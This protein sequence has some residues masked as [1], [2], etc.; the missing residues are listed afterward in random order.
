MIS[1]I[2]TV[3]NCSALSYR[4]QWKG[5]TMAKGK[6]GLFSGMIPVFAV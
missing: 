1:S 2:A 6:H 3:Y 5:K 4:E